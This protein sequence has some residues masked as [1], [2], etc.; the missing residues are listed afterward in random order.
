MRAPAIITKSSDIDLPLDQLMDLVQQHTIK[1]FLD[2]CDP[3][4]KLRYGRLN[5]DSTS[6]N[7]IIGGR[8]FD[9]MA[10]LIA[11]LRGRM[12]RS[13]A[14]ER[15]LLMLSALLK[16]ERFHGAFPDFV[17]AGSL[18]TCTFSRYDDDGDV[19]ETALLLQG[20]R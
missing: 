4:S 19:V 17:D 15:I 14:V 10:I 2:A 1:Y 8:V 18:K 16:V 6:P 11:V 9:F 3:T 7:G 13:D 12:N 20:L 5:K